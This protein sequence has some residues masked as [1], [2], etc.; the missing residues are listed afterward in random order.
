MLALVLAISSAVMQPV[1]ATA[2]DQFL[3]GCAVRSIVSSEPLGA[4][5]LGEMPLGKLDDELEFLVAGHLYGQPGLTGRGWIARNFRRSIP[6]LR[7]RQPD[8][9]VSL[10][11]F[12]R[13]SDPISFDVSVGRLRKLHV[14]VFNTPGNHDVAGGR[15]GYERR[16]GRTFGALRRGRNLLIFLD[17]ERSPWNLDRVQVAF[18]ER[19]L[20]LARPSA[21][22]DIRN[23]FL[24]AH[25]VIFAASE[26]RYAPL[27]RHCNSR[28]GF[29]GS[30]F[31]AEVAP[32][33]SEFRRFAGVYWF[34]GDVG[35]SWSYG[36]FYD[37]H[38]DSG[39]VYCATGVGD[40]EHDNILSVRVDSEGAVEIEVIAL[41]GAPLPALTRCG[42]EFWRSRFRALA[43]SED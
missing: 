18:L 33:L 16:F 3:E 1:E 26:P 32:L 27:L 20:M 39:V 38:P 41:G 2:L 5:T 25:R 7:A 35:V 9:L 29:S 43:E 34:S 24:F 40:T 30:N 13:S 36:L 6:D 23:V 37:R 21:K 31:Q 8:F 17:T 28:S 15:A 4:V 10:G 12:V 42:P 11:D 14:P 22:A 19:L